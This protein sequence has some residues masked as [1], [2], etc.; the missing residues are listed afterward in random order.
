MRD[1]KAVLSELTVAGESAVVRG[2][3]L[4]GVNSAH[5][6]IKDLFQEALGCDVKVV[7]PVL[8]PRV[9]GFS[10]DDLLVQA[11]LARLMGLGLG[12]LPREQLLSCQLPEISSQSTVAPLLFGCCSNNDTQCRQTQK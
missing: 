5:P 9:A 2:L 12:F 4:S 1:V 6:L 7:N 10:P 8:M 3:S 11:G